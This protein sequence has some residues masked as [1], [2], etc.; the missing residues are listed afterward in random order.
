MKFEPLWDAASSKASSLNFLSD[1]RVRYV[2][3]ADDAS[4][5]NASL[6]PSLTPKLTNQSVRRYLQKKYLQLRNWRGNSLNGLQLHSTPDFTVLDYKFYHQLYEFYKVGGLAVVPY[7][8]SFYNSTTRVEQKLVQEYPDLV[9]EYPV[10]LSLEQL[11]RYTQMKKKLLL[12]LGEYDYNS[13]LAH[14]YASN[15][16]KPDKKVRKHTWY[17]VRQVELKLR[18]TYNS[19]VSGKVPVVT[20]KGNLYF[21]TELWLRSY[22]R[23]CDVKKV[24]SFGSVTYT[25]YPRYLPPYFLLRTNVAL[26][27]RWVAKELARL[28]TSGYNTFSNF[29]RTDLGVQPSSPLNVYVRNVGLKDYELTVSKL[30]NPGSYVVRNG[31]TVRYK[32]ATKELSKKR[33]RA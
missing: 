15:Y 32:L 28:V 2:Q 27:Q 26:V 10:G 33:T 21:W 31:E 3:V 11:S 17:D 14:F 7:E 25:L 9:S 24:T 5:E 19:S 30:W 8:L 20:F 23:S 13:V 12:G 4:T 6:N 16:Y 18:S 22:L 1:Y 29:V